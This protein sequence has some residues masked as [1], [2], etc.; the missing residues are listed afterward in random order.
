[1][2]MQRMIWMGLAIGGLVAMT[3][4]ADE[5]PLEPAKLVVPR[6]GLGNVLAKLDGGKDVTVAYFGGSITAMA[7]WRTKT[8]AWLQEQWPNAKIHEVHAAI[9]GTPSSLGAFR[10][11]HDVLDHKPDL[12][13]VEF[14]VNDGG[15]APES[16]YRSMEGIVRQ[17]WTADPTIDICFVYTFR[18]GY[19]QQLHDGLCPRAPSAHEVIANHYGIPSINW[20]L[21]ISELEQQG[22][23]IFK[24]DPANPPAEGVVIFSNDGV[25]PAD[26]GHE[27]YLDVSKQVLPEI[28]AASKVGPH[29]LP[30]PYVEDNWQAAKMVEVSQSML[31]GQWTK[32]PEDHGFVKSFGGRMM[33][34][35]EATTPG[36]TL[37]FKFKG[38]TC[39]LYD[40]LGPDGGNVTITLDGK[41]RGPVGRFDSYCTYH[42]LATLGIGSGLEDTVHTVKVELLST[43]PDRSSVTD[44]EKDKPNFNPAKYDGTGLRIGGILMIGELVD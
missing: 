12:V 41:E 17:I 30:A 44:R 37:E 13:F 9:G 28:Q 16:I 27:I 35:W 36:A 7:G 11:Q 34:M 31:G 15:A 25:H 32:L 42:R 5:P 8:T 19:E 6:E 14:S 26:A 22:K 33:Q 39:M 3:V 1:M 29:A 43:Q 24:N 18:V 21:R 20:A 4:A 38:T 2:A 23:L 10:L 40:L